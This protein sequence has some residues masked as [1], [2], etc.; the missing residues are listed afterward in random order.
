MVGW[1]I[2]RHETAAMVSGALVLL[3][4]VCAALGQTRVYPA[5]SQHGGPAWFEDFAAKAGIRVLNANGG[6]ESKR[7]ILEATGSGVAIFDYDND[8]WP[9]IYMVN[10]GLLPGQDQK[11]QHPTSHLFHNNHNGTF[12]DVTA[13]AGLTDTAWGQGA[14]VGDYDNDGYDDLFVTAYGK[15]RL[16]H[17]QG[18]GTFK[19]VAASAGVAGTGKLWGTGCAFVDY[20]RDGKL[21]LAVANYVSFDLATT[22]APGASASCTWKGVPV[23]CGPRGLASSPNLLYRNLGNGKFADVSKTSG[24]EKTEGHYCFSVSTIDYDE[25]GWPDIFVACDSTPAILYRNN[26][27]GTFT[28]T[29]ADTGVAF[30]DDGREQA[31]MGSSIGDFDGD[32]HLDIVKTNFSDDTSTLYHHNAD[33]SFSDVTFAS[34]VGTNTQYL[35]WGC[36]FLDVD[37]DG[38]PDILLVN[39]HVY[40]EVDSGNMGSAYREPRVLY[41]NQGNG[42][43]KDISGESGPGI[44]QPESS[45]GLAIGDLWND[46]RMEAVVND[47][48]DFPLLLVNLARNDNHWLGIHLIGVASNR[49]GIGARV[50][51]V[52]PEA[53]RVW[54]DEVRSGSSYSSNNDM[55][56]HFG[57]GQATHVASIEVRWPSGRSEVFP[58]V[59]ADQIISL[60]EGSGRLKGAQ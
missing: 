25:D 56:L 55:R 52:G 34:G 16:Y 48:S 60:K 12:T 19:E 1:Q 21:D 46:G 24:F 41:W 44:T 4:S 36:M 15:N 42:K 51:V 7:Y 54:V 58:G 14:C 59:A 57:L 27:D 53:S 10:G 13:R 3:L 17:N 32:G 31:G 11:D 26:H 33:H 2:G 38:R 9:D 6:V 43:F 20:D 39:G 28:D 40:P 22:P 47:V 29:A 23:M 8:G 45:R 35:G 30:N 50:V 18:N 49:D 5:S 37:N